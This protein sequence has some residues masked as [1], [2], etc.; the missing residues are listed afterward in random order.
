MRI[1]IVG[2]NY[3]PEPIGIGPYTAGTA[4][5]L[6]EAGHDVEVLTGKAYYPDWKIDPA[7]AR[8][9]YHRSVE[10]GVRI[11]RCPLYVPSRDGGLKRIVHHAS[12]AAAALPEVVRI[13]RRFR[14][15]LVL[16]IAPS[17]VSFPVARVAARIAGAELWLHIQDFEVEAAFATGLMDSRSLL[18]RAAAGFEA[19]QLAAADRITSISPQMCARLAAK[20]VPED[21]IAQFRNWAEIEHI[22]PLEA[23]SP[24]RQEWNIA[25]PFV[26]FYSGNIAKKQGIGIIV[27]AARLLRH[28]RDLVFVICGEG[29]NRAE[30]EREAASLGN[31]RLFDLQ[32]RDRLGELLGLATLHLLP[33]LADAA[34]LVLPSKLANMMASGRPVVA[35]AAPGTGIANEIADC[36]ISTPPGDAV[37]F[38]AAIE[39]LLDDAEQRAQLGLAARNAAESRWSR[40][41]LLGRFCAL[42]DSPRPAP[43]KTT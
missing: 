22:R 28:R 34:D 8:P 38:A 6:R 1:L 10:D 14:P 12:F 18:A 37:A 13:A 43:S 27:E 19:Q 40:E 17:L 7:F 9:A 32:P 31:I 42:V 21:R 3:A 33:Q 39:A 30:L 20:G 23:P 15:E 24:Y 2:I 5:A 4:R 25:E 11:T 41:E 26:A 29:P 36:G 16:A 35:T